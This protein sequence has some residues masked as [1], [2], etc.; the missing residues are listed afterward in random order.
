MAAN[1]RITEDFV[2][3]RLKARSEG[4]IIEEQKSSNARINKYLKSAS[5]QGGGCGYPDFIISHKEDSNFLVVIECKADS[6]FHESKDKDKY[7]DYAVDGALLYA[8]YLRQDF[9]VIAIGVSG[10]DKKRMLVT[11]YLCLKNTLEQ[12][13]LAGTWLDLPDL[14]EKYILDEATREQRY[15]ELLDYSRALNNILHTYKIK[16]DRRSLLLSAILIALEEKSF[17]NFRQCANTAELSQRLVHTVMSKLRGRSDIK[18]ETMDALE[19]AY[20]F[21]ELDGT[22]PS[23]KERVIN[24]IDGVKDNIVKFRKTYEYYDVFGEFYIE[25][26][27]YANSDKKLGIVL[28]PKHIT[29]LFCDVAGVSKESVVFDNCCGTGGFLISAMR[30]MIKLAEGNSEKVKKIKEGQ[31]IGIETQSEIYPLACSNMITHDDGKTNLYRG[32]CFDEQIIKE[33]KEFKPNTG[34]LNPPYKKP[35]AKDDTQELL[36]VIN[37]LEALEP[38]GICVAL[39]PMQCA[40]SQ[41]GERL[42]LKSEIM[43]KHTLEAVVSMPNEIFHN[44]KVGVV[45]CAMV[46]KAHSPHPSN[47]KTYFGYWKDDG[48]VKRKNKGRIDALKQWDDIK[49]KWLISYRNRA[50]EKGLSV[51]KEVK[52]RDEWCAE[53][54]METDYSLLNEEKFIETIKQFIAF[55]FLNSIFI[56]SSEEIPAGQD[57]QCL[58]KK[59][60]L[61]KKISLNDREWKWF[62]YKEIFEITGS[63]T[64]S[65]LELEE[66]GKGEYPYVTTQ[67]TNNGVAGYYNIETEQGNV[68]TVDSAVAGYCAYQSKN[69]S[70]SDHVEKLVPKFKMNTYSAMF[71]VTLINQ[72]KYRYNYGRKCSQERLKKSSIKLPVTSE[73]V[74]DWQFMEDYIKSLSWSKNL[75]NHIIL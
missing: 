38:H 40:I 4:F 31:I 47:Y 18:A 57:L 58:T 9:D 32:N 49:E 26:L 17:S 69:F 10:Q 23:D 1:E 7:K 5:K 48:F 54:Y 53:A 3:E 20:S 65:L 24:L 2:R 72:E 39:L 19:S 6:K 55:Q 59:A 62:S 8:S 36:F 33:V 66:I 73:S 11:S 70:A 41:K 60:L 25:F 14:Q 74:P 63:R 15:E 35:S 29:E 64:T 67:E 22:L 52:P 30:K 50:D 28:T 42:N 61:S 51:L 16:E 34:L 13:L 12:K 37:N 45:T 44:S 21:I 75:A 56:P 46:I 68:L 71:L 43:T 27:R